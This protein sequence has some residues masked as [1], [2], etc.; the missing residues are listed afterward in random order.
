MDFFNSCSVFRFIMDFNE[1]AACE[2]P[3]AASRK[4]DDNFI[5]S[6]VKWAGNLEEA[7]DIIREF[8]VKT[9]TKF[10]LYTTDKNFGNTDKF[11]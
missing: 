3:I 10:T 1:N 2:K 9:T 7:N 8:E 11:C 6:S 5:K 4:S